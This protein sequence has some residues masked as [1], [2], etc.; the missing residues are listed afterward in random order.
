MDIDTIKDPLVGSKVGNLV[1]DERI[2][3]GGFGAVYRAHHVHIKRQHAVKI[4]HT[5]LAGSREVVDRFHREAQLLAEIEHPNVVNITDFGVLAQGGLYLVMEFLKG[6]PMSD[7]MERRRPLPMEQILRIF[8]QLLGVLEEVHRRGIVHRDLKPDNIFL[9]AGGAPDMIK[10]LDFGIARVLQGTDGMNQTATGQVMGTPG[11][12]SP[13]QASGRVNLIG[14]PADLYSAGVMLFQCLTGKLPFESTVPWEVIRSHIMEEPPTLVEAR[15]GTAFPQELEELVADSLAKEPGDRFK[16]A[17]AFLDRLLKVLSTSE[18][19]VGEVLAPFGGAFGPSSQTRQ[20]PIQSGTQEVSHH[21]GEEPALPGHTRPLGAQEDG[22]E[23][24]EAMPAGLPGSPTGPQRTEARAGGLREDPAEGRIL[25][26][27]RKAYEEDI[28]RRTTESQPVAKTRSEAA[29]LETLGPGTGEDRGDQTEVDAPPERASGGTIPLPGDKRIPSELSD[30]SADAFL[31]T[32][33]PGSAGLDTPQPEPL[34]MEEAEQPDD[35][36]LDPSAAPSTPEPRKPDRP[37]RTFVREGEERS[38]PPTEK[39]ERA[40]ESKKRTLIWFMLSFLLVVGGGLGGGAWYVK[41]RSSRAVPDAGGTA[42]ATIGQPPKGTPVDA[43][44]SS[45]DAGGDGTAAPPKKPTPARASDRPGKGGGD[46]D[47]DDDARQPAAGAP[48]KGRTGGRAGKSRDPRGSRRSRRTKRA[49][50]RTRTRR[51]KPRRV[52]VRKTRQPKPAPKPKSGRC[53]ADA[54]AHR[55]VRFKG[56]RAKARSF[57][58]SGALRMVVVGNDACVK[59]PRG[60]RKVKLS[61]RRDALL[62]HRCIISLPSKV[63]T[64]SFRPVGSYDLAPDT[65]DCSVKKR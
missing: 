35:T 21:D 39:V 13:E 5:H 52:A 14:P 20:M 25:A 16:S 61:H 12:I 43:G 24:T 49:L 55:W 48:D 59:L 27:P 33:V 37:T 32:I 63:R 65:P 45:P 17:R 50:P 26:A 2:G 23:K 36:L 47:D 3:E 6:Q 9:I 58:Y 8:F 57:R 40:P 15:P 42:A 31:E 46:D 22:P 29:M 64:V 1:L 41:S 56:V 54:G 10:V 51:R 44:G 60:G 4:L 53:P 19:P 28:T 30:T 18:F 62:Y 38:V 34:V 7:L 11:Y